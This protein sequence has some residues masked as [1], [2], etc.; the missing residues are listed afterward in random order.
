MSILKDRELDTVLKSYPSKGARIQ[1]S[2]STTARHQPLKY[3]LNR[4]HVYLV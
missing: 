3:D 2:R 4:G 1:H